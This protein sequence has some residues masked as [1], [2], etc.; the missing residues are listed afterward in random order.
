[1]VR[2]QL[3]RS[4]KQGLCDKTQESCSL[5]LESPTS[6][7]Q[8]SSLYVKKYAYLHLY[9]SERRAQRLNPETGEHILQDHNNTFQISTTARAATRVGQPG[10][11]PPWN[12]KKHM[13]LLDTTSY[14]QF[15]PSE[16]ISWLWPGQQSIM[17]SHSVN[18]F[19][20]GYMIS[21][22]VESETWGLGPRFS[23]LLSRWSTA[24]EVGFVTR[25]WSNRQSMSSRAQLASWQIQ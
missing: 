4:F 22:T 24:E 7:K 23:G 9:G 6:R 13:Q 21:W 12:F 15:P 8:N 19:P 5:R 14:N 11:W 17:T 3:W 25:S 2:W 1:M 10:N 20:P 18:S 16:K